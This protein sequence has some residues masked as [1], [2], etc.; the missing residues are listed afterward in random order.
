MDKKPRPGRNPKTGEAYEI[1]AR[2]TVSMRK[3]PQSEKPYLKR[4][5]MLSKLRD[6]LSGFENIDVVKIYNVF[7]DF[8]KNVEDKSHRVEFRG[9]GIFYPSVRAAGEVRNPKTGEKRFQK[10]VFE[11]HFDR[12][13]SY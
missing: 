8:I 11:F 4:Q 2:R 7:H 13:K 10:S 9:L 5:D 1:S 12:L 6:A 3:A